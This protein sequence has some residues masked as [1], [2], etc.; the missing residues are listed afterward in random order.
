MATINSYKNFEFPLKVKINYNN[1]IMFVFFKAVTI[2]P[3]S[4]MLILIKRKATWLTSK[5]NYIFKP[6]PINL[7]VNGGFI[8]LLIN[9]ST[10]VIKA[11]NTLKRLVVIPQH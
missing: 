7:G 3:K 11:I 9:T 5:I 8:I 6:A 4:T 10:E 1:P 2:P